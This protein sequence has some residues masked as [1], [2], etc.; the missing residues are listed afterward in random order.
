MVSHLVV[1]SNFSPRVVFLNDESG[2]CYQIEEG[3]D[4]CIHSLK[5]QH[6]AKN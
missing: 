5:I 3:S 2:E 4:T 1:D 6:E